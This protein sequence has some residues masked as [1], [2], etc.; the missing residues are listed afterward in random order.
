MGALQTS[1]FC[2]V[3]NASS[4]RCQ[5]SIFVLVWLF[6]LV[7]G[8][9]IRG[10][11]R[12]SIGWVKWWKVGE[13]VVQSSSP[14]QPHERGEKLEHLIGDKKSHPMFHLSIGP[15]PSASAFITRLSLNPRPST[16]LLLSRSNGESSTKSSNSTIGSM[17]TTE[18]AGREGLTKVVNV[19]KEH[20]NEVMVASST[21]CL[22]P[23]TVVLHADFRQ[24]DSVAALRA[25]TRQKGCLPDKELV[26]AS[27]TPPPHP[28][29][30]CKPS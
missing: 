29:P 22:H 1:L 9:P 24:L 11:G 23:F 15:Q 8:G 3:T 16:P 21:S 20:G 13:S 28:L 19:R 12:L 10:W 26:V 4:G 14:A 2:L 27:L 25:G 5:C 30:W 6:F 17:A 7:A 18:A